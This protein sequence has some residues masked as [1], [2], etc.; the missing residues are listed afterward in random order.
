MKTIALNV[1]LLALCAVAQGATV[2]YVSPTGNNG[3]NGTSTNTPFQTL[4]YAANRLTSAGDTLYMR[5]GTYASSGT[6]TIARS[7]TPTARIKI[8]PYPGDAMPVIDWS[9]NSV[10]D[11][12]WLQGSNVDLCGL[13]IR[14]SGKDGVEMV[15]RYS[16][17]SQCK[18]HNT[19]NAAVYFWSDHQTCQ[20]NIVY[21]NGLVNYPHGAVD[22]W[23]AAIS[24]GGGTNR[25]DNIIRRNIVYNNWCEGITMWGAGSNNVVE[26]NVSYDNFAANLYL[27]GS[28]GNLF[29]RNISYLTAGNAFL[30]NHSGL[31]IT[32]NEVSTY[33]ANDNKIINNLFFQTSTSVGKAISIFPWS[34]TRMTN[35]I[36][37]NNTIINVALYGPAASLIGTGNVFANNIFSTGN[38]VPGAGLIWSNNLWSGSRPANAVGTGDI[39]NQNPRVAATGNTGPGQLTADY[40]RLLSNSPAI[41]AGSSIPQR[42]ADYFG[43]GFV[44][45]P[46]IG[47]MEYGAGITLAI[48]NTAAGAQLRVAGW[49]GTNTPAVYASTNL[50][51]WTP[52]CTSAPAASPI[53]YLD[54]AAT[55]FPTRVYRASIRP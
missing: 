22:T 20:D 8:L 32:G 46:D 13:E 44:G 50:V 15:G 21:S 37:A 10:N 34:T 55:N 28:S 3:N 42:T 51:A 1:W 30:T 36:F 35:V 48:S 24:M 39:V 5:G 43:L 26:D 4:N 38:S 27:E 40:F 47:A 53:Q 17:V 45:T 25:S 54:S 2:Y 23:P 49:G 7:G 11:Y 33:L 12:I 6:I 29:Q 14:N 16:T 18:I 52:I 31:F 9:F 41:N 19:M